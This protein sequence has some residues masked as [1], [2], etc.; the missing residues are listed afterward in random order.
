MDQATAA[1]VSP[2]RRLLERGAVRLPAG[3]PGVPDTRSPARLLVWVGRQQV[4]TLLLGVFFGVVWMVS[5]ALMPFTIGRAIQDGIV[6][7]DNHALAGWTLL[8]LALGAT[9]AGAG[10]MRHRFAVFNWLQ[11]SFRMAQVVSHHA[12]RAGPAVRGRLSTGEVVATVS[13]DA[14]RAGGA[15]D[16]TARLSGA[17]VSYLVVAAILLSSSVALGVIVLVG[18]PVLVLLLGF[19]I[20]PL[21]ARQREQREE[22]GQL[23]ALGADTAAGLRVLRGIGGESGFFTRYCR[24]SQAVRHTGVRVALPQ[25][26]LDAAQ[27]FIP[28]LFVVLVTWIGA[29]FAISGDID[30]GELVAFYGYAAFLVLPLR[31]AAEAVDKVTRAH[32]GARRMLDVLDV[33]RHVAEPV[34]PV[35][36][37]PRGVPL[38]DAASGLVVEPGLL[39]C[40][41]SSRPDEAAALADRLGRFGDDDGVFLGDVR[42]A[43]LPISV[44]RRRIVVSESD[45]VLFSGTLRS[46]LDPW[47]RATDDGDI[48]AAISIA[49]AEDVL[50]ALPEGLD[51][52][53]DERGRSF[54]G[55]QRQRLVLSRALLSGAEVL[56]LVEPTSAVD[57]HTE[58]RIARRLR[59]ARAGLTTVVVTTS[60]LMLDQADRVVLV[61]DGRVVAEGGH[62]E[63]LRTNP[64]YR[65][66]VTRGEEL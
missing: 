58:A 16:I 20:K 42:L 32:V 54:S 36:E 22:V 40:I 41:V 23:T 55:G 37:P 60:P 5:Q 62:R 30:S 6:G 48:L 35:S 13:N 29:R 39:T 50:Q 65:D 53:V 21:Q 19:V 10:I 49:S 46:E 31:T 57:A 9:Q 11:A 56:V 64:D 12:A 18:V 25:S 45:P 47:R 33:E 43:E 8:L 7:Q 15:F 61:E 66:T 38:V 2:V 17:L 3:D 26:T 24:R 27:V 34:S 28:G 51:T 44:V 52:R 1:T 63:L 59:D 4:G 14:M